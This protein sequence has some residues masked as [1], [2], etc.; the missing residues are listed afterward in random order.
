[1]TFTLTI[2]VLHQVS[3]TRNYY[4]V[5]GFSAFYSHDISFRSTYV[6][7]Y[8]LI[9]INPR[10][11]SAPP[12]TQ[13]HRINLSVSLWLP[14]HCRLHA[15]A[16]AHNCTTS[17]RPPSQMLLLQFCYRMPI[18]ATWGTLLSSRSSLMKIVRVTILY[19]ALPVNCSYVPKMVK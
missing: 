15:G 11:K 14:F 12:H 19:S 2:L 18:S 13:L 9:W 5:S 7:A 17:H 8:T 16:I 10:H 3:L 4:C 6:W 1:M